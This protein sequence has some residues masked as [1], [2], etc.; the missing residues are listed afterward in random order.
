MK[1]FR[2]RF[3]APDAPEVGIYVVAG[4][5]HDALTSFQAS[6]HYNRGVIRS[7][8]LLGETGEDLILPHPSDMEP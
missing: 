2:I 8:G 5:Y 6:G 1:L 7:I 4:D 3:K